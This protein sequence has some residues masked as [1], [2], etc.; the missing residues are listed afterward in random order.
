MKCLFILKAQN[1]TLLICENNKLKYFELQEE[2]YLDVINKYLNDKINYNHVEIKREKE[3]IYYGEQYKIFELSIEEFTE[4]NNATNIKYISELIPS[5]LEYKDLKFLEIFC[6]DYCR[7]HFFRD[8]KLNN[9]EKSISK[10]NIIASIVISL[11]FNI[12]FIGINNNSYLGISV[13]IVVLFFVFGA[14][15]TIGKIK[16]INFIGLYLLF[17]GILLSITYSIFTNPLLRT[18]NL[19]LVPLSL[20][21]GSFMIAFPQCEFTTKGIISNILPNI[22]INIFN[23]SKLDIIKK[24]LDG[25][26]ISKIRND[27]N[28]AILKGIIISI[29]ILIILVVLLSSADGMFAIVFGNNLY[30]FLNAISTISPKAIVIRT[31]IFM[32]V[33]IYLYYLFST[34][35]FII[36]KDYKNK[37][38]EIDKNIAN[39]ILISINSL[40]L[41][42][43]YVQIKYLYIKANISM[44]SEEYSEYARSGFFQLLLVVILNII[45]IVL[46]KS[47]IRNNRTTNI[48]NTLI[49]VISMGMTFSS[50]YKM[51][52]YID[53]YGMTRMRFL[54][55]I[56]MFFILWI[57]GFILVYLW[58]NINLY[59]YSIVIG[60]ILYLSISFCNM[61]K[62]IARYNIKLN[63]NEVDVEY[64]SNLSLDCYDI[65]LQAYEDGK[66]EKDAFERYLDGKKIT[67]KWYEYN[68]YN[69]RKF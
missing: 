21:T 58:K 42:F 22:T 12:F 49:T 37:S 28:L 60:S 61:D 55:S 51:K 3:V 35:R 34:F 47:R 19:I 8:V 38:K 10:K 14:V 16:K 40:Y 56:F 46:F 48:L 52:L 24:S 53:N 6:K 54:T 27:K 43:C 39:T 15:F 67:N 18:I 33:F 25:R 59:K 26:K 2:H 65:V 66:I 29:P 5:N 7:V 44:T 50:M 62:F 68:Y 20:I 64:L 36:K 45:I 4:V 23:D 1:N 57:L 69:N 41:I 9:T 63:G 30:K 31:V 11:L 17:I 32:V 13:P